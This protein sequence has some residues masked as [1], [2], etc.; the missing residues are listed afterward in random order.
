[1]WFLSIPLAGQMCTS[2][3]RSARTAEDAVRAGSS[4]LP[5][6]CD[7]GRCSR[8][9][10]V[11]TWQ[12]AQVT[13]WGPSLGRC[14]EERRYCPTLD[15]F[16]ASISWQTAPP[17]T[18]PLLFQ[19]IIT[20]VNQSFNEILHGNRLHTN[21]Q[22]RWKLHLHSRIMWQHKLKTDVLSDVLCCQANFQENNPSM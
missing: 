18:P 5:S 4:C 1:M 15:F 16:F 8:K 10:Y 22:I 3:R 12:R 21:T 13:I 6:D 17:P 20:V 11:A 2:G 14:L 9:H 19:P 7:F